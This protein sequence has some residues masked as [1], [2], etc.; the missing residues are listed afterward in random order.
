MEDLPN[1]E[2]KRMSVTMFKPFKEGIKLLQEEIMGQRNEVETA[3]Q[4]VNIALTKEVELLKKTQV[5]MML[6]VKKSISQWK[7]HVKD[8]SVGRTT[9]RATNQCGMPTQRNCF[10]Q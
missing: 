9:R 2:F 4:D 7:P 5:K 1:E 3:I 6:G 8:E 10:T